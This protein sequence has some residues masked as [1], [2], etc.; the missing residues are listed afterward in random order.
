MRFNADI[1]SIDDYALADRILGGPDGAGIHREPDL[2]IS[3]NGHP[4]LYRWHIVH[5][6]NKANVYFHIQVASDPERPLHDHPWDNTSVVLSGGY[7]EVW[8]PQPWLDEHH[9]SIAHY[10]RKLRSGNVVHRAAA[11]A[12]RLIL[13]EHI[14]YTMSL[15]STGPKVRE[16]GFWFPDRW[17]SFKEVT[18]IKE[19]V[20]QFTQEAF[21]ELRPTSR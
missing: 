14:P 5:D 9:P 16:W 1:L 12:H 19:G 10:E 3:P 7:D 18:E 15:F 21:H 8:S 20:S 13:P 6:Q 2:V 4:Y 17:R 11:E